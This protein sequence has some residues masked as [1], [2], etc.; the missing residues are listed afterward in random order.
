MY[1][2]YTVR[3]FILARKD[4]PD[5]NKRTTQWHYTSWPDMGVPENGTSLLKF[6]QR[7]HQS[8]PKQSGPMVVHCSAGVGRT[9]TF[10]TLGSM[11]PM[12]REQGLIDV[13]NFVIKMRQSRN[14]MVQVEA[15]YVF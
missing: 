13:Y 12:I 5:Q 4:Y 11:M 6:V 2:H 7:V 1:A 8:H 10:I 9:G 14:R 3:E 15:Q